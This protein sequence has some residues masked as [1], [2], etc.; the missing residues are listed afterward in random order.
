MSFLTGDMYIRI[1][2]RVFSTYTCLLSLLEILDH[3]VAGTGMRHVLKMLTGDTDTPRV[4]SQVRHSLI[5][6]WTAQGPWGWETDR[7]CP[8]GKHGPDKMGLGG[9]ANESGLRE[10]ENPC[11][12]VGWNKGASGQF[13][14]AQFSLEQELNEGVKASWRRRPL[15]YEASQLYNLGGGHFTSKSAS[16]WVKG[17]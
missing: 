9:H 14:F 6:V 4:E 17:V 15:K 10:G 8:R 2:G 5:Q 13:C 11:R 1:T 12:L 7:M 16:S 3:R